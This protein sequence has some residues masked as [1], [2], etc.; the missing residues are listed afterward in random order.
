M[1]KE[2]HKPGQD[3]ILEDGVGYYPA[4]VHDMAT[5]ETARRSLSAMP[6][7]V[8]HHAGNPRERL[9]VA[10]F[11]G[12][13]NDAI[14]NPQHATNI[15][16]IREQLQTLQKGGNKNIRGGYVEGIGTQRNVVVR[17]LDGGIGFTYDER[18]E[19]M[20]EQLIRRVADWKQEDP[21]AEIRVVDIGFSRGAEQ[22][23]SFARLIHE[24]GIQDWTGIEKTTD[25]SG[26]TVIQYTKPPLIPPGRV[27]QAVGLFDPV[28]TGEPRNHDRRLP[29][30]VISGF[31]ITA[32]DER[33]GLFKSTSIIDQG[34]TADGRFLGVMVG[35]AHSDVGGG[36]HRNGLSARSGNLMVDYLNSLSDTPFLQ[37]KPEPG[38]PGM[39]VVHRS[40][41]GMLLYRIWNKV[42]RQ[43]HDGVV[44]QLAPGQ[45][46]RKVADCRN[47]E[48]RDEAMAGRFESAT[49]KI[50]PVP[51]E[52]KVVDLPIRTDA[53]QPGHP[54]HALL[55]QS[56]AAVSRL[57]TKLHRAP[58]LSSDRLA[59]GVAVAAKQAGL[60][61]V[62]HVVLSDRGDYA[63][64][65]QG[66]LN[67]PARHMAR[68]DTKAVTN[69]PVDASLM[70]I[71]AL[72][73]DLMHER[74]WQPQQMALP[75]PQEET[76]A[77]AIA[78]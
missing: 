68:I 65:I 34:M 26:R 16:E 7:P 64:A 45:V 48:P 69:T 51:T 18:L 6:A 44:E 46:C 66:D 36:Y 70:Q 5:F 15:G 29:S 19:K 20:Y 56:V 39:N 22:A 40:E 52:S 50:G 12:T 77:R 11:D 25:A 31:Q 2:R 43:H 17:M 1:S 14:R 35:G 8:L 13:G 3:G 41:E 67:S 72:N 57:E 33:R 10:G 42:D 58:D 21:K 28:G 54:D 53:T 27:A 61:R 23:A 63:F 71:N 74:R 30:S 75:S 9:F 62:D 55:V 4:D 47:A 37:K 49:V 32:E 76:S 73:D 24:R 59:T 78:R 60:Q 38:S